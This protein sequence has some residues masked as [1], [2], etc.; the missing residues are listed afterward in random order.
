MLAATNRDLEKLA[1]EGKFR[2]DLFFR[3][4]VLRIHMPPLRERREDI[5]LLARHFVDALSAESGVMRKTLLPVTV[6]KLKML[7]WPGNVREL[8]NVIQRAFVAAEGSDILPVHL[9]ISSSQAF[10]ENAVESFMQAK[11]KVVGSFERQYVVDALQKCKGNITEAARLAK[12]DRR[13]FGRLVK[14]HKIDRAELQ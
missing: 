12:K 10:E 14:R 11:A 5:P 3:L 2:S 4:S 7:D 6:H 9:Q 8:Y 13:A 1:Q